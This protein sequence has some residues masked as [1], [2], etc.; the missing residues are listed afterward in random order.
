MSGGEAGQGHD[1]GMGSAS[2]RFAG[3]LIRHPVGRMVAVSFLILFLEMACIR[4]FGSTVPFLAY[5][6]NL[7]LLACFLGMS[8]GCM[9]CRSGRDFFSWSQPLLVVTV[10]CALALEWAFWAFGRVLIDVGG[11]NSPQQVF[12]GAEYAA[13]N[14]GQ[15]VVP[16]E[17]VAGFFFLLITGVFLGLGQELGLSLRMVASPIAGYSWNIAASLAGIVTFSAFSFAQ[18]DPRGWFGVAGALYLVL[19]RERPIRQAVAFVLLVAVVGWGS[20]GQ[21][22]D[23]T[24][25]WSPYYRVMHRTRSG[26]IRVNHISHQNMIDID[27]VGSAYRLTYLLVRDAGGA[28][29]RHGLIVGAGSGNDVA[30]AVRS[31]VKHVDAVDLEPV[32]LGIG[33]RWHPNR[34]YSNTRVSVFQADGRQFLRRSGQVYDF[35]AYALPDS[36]MLHSGYA[37]LRLESF[38]YT[39]EAFSDVRAALEPGGIFAIYNVYR[40]WWVA[41]RVAA[42]AREVFGV[43]PIVF[44]LPYR[45]RIGPGGAAGSSMT[46]ILVSNGASPRLEGIRERLKSDGSFWLNQVP[47]A[48]VA[49]NGFG[50]R[51]P[52]TAVEAAGPWSRIAP[53]RV[54]E[55]G[56]GRLPSDDWPFLYLREARIPDLN[57]RGMVLIG[58]V[59][60]VLLSRLVPKG[61]NGMSGTMFFL[62]A[63]FM[64]LET[65]ATVQMALL[66]GSTWVVS[67]IVI[68]SILVMILVANILVARVGSGWVSAAWVGL[69]LTMGLNLVFPPSRFLGLPPVL[70]V[71]GVCT[72]SFAPILFAGVLFASFFAQSPSP[73]RDFGANVAG[74]LLGGLS[75]NLSMVIGFQGLL[76]LVIGYY[77]LA[78]AF[79]VMKVPGWVG[80]WSRST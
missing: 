65:R 74:A 19:A 13:R 72:L 23:E 76:L 55:Q 70:Q 14:P 11:Q 48:S 39:K 5:F 42:L 56:M 20:V 21:L 60:A 61:W 8:V 3:G 46:M 17:V 63:A 18:I 31:G 62:G 51:P 43:E 73:D 45:E 28:P 66:F 15:F 26:A 7:V 77:G 37:S 64:L 53:A 30:A 6:S 1:L 4:W 10:V 25:T 68:A 41:A 79:R 27:T 35:V 9:A 52:G 67:A 71:V 54:E 34:P 22:R 16:I 38:L 78:W 24:T 80:R 59:A 44:S 58:L 12:F 57:L 40:Q 2:P 32:I 36:L 49:A 33:S 69:F 29:F 50:A 75:E 47:A